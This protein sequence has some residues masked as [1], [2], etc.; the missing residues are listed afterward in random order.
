M[1]LQRQ[2]LEQAGLR[3]VEAYLLIYDY[4]DGFYLEHQLAKRE[5]SM[6][7]LIEQHSQSPCIVQALELL[8]REIGVNRTG[9]I[10]KPTNRLG[11]RLPEGYE[12]IILVRNF[13]TVGQVLRHDDLE[14][15]RLIDVV[16]Q[17]FDTLLEISIVTA[18]D[19]DY[20][21]GG[22]LRGSH[23]GG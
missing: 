6:Q 1:Q 3:L 8:E 4:T 22:L 9:R 5:V 15:G 10:A 7:R 13:G 17:G 19:D 12:K 14:P 2:V 23:R 18:F 21:T 20:L 16:D 11:R